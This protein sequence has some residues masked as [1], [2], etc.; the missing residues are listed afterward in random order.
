MEFL[1][2]SMVDK[3]GHQLVRLQGAMEILGWMEK[4]APQ[5]DL[6]VSL[7]CHHTARTELIYKPC[8]G[9]D[10]P[11]DGPT[12][13]QNRAV[14]HALFVQIHRAVPQLLGVHRAWRIHVGGKR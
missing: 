6:F 7:L 9:A 12:G 5:F 14:T 2:Q 4:Q 10:M 8:I 3:H 1:K 13:G 11:R